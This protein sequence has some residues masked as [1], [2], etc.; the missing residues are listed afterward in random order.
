MLGINVLNKIPIMADPLWVNILLIL[1]GIIFS[2]GIIF[3]I[4]SAYK[5]SGRMLITGFILFAISVVSLIVCSIYERSVPT[6]KYKYE[7]TIDKDVSFTELNSKY[8][9]I[10]QRGNIYILEDK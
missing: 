10:E 2:T 3:I 4:I 8:N 5:I 6:G 9:I 7:V 1:S